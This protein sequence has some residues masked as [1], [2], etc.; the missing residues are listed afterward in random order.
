MAINE[1]L[2]LGNNVSI[3]LTAKDLLEVIQYTVL[4]TRKELE[5]YISE[6]NSEEYLSPK[7]VSVMLGIS[8]VSLW[9]Y[10]KKGYLTPIEVG[11]KRKYLKSD[12]KA[13]LSKREND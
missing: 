7:E 5:Q 11:G 3:T 9:R 8:N 1:L 13:L 6:S 2:T 10:A 12:I 4:E